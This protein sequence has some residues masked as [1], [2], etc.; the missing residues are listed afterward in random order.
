MRQIYL[1]IMATIFVFTAK[2]QSVAKFDDLSLTPESFWNG[3]DLSGSFKSG[4]VTFLNSFNIDWQNWSGFAYSNMSDVTTPG[5]GNQYSAITGKGYEESSNYA[6]C[7]PS[8]TADMGITLPGRITGFFV[9]NSTYAYLS[10]K[11]GDA[12]AKKFGGETGNDPDFFKLVIET[13]DAIGQPVDTLDFYL[14]DFRSVDNSK[15]YIL[16]NWTWVDLSAMKLTGNLRFSLSSGDN[17]FG[18]MNTPG[19]FC[20]DNLNYAVMV[21]SSEIQKKQATVF[22]NPFI[23][24]LNISG[25]D[26]KAKVI[27]SDLSGKTISEYNNVLNNKLINGLSGLKSGVYFIKIIDENNQFTT[28]LVKK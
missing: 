14:A 16:N 17:S 26:G 15:D 28:K 5:Y 24:Q 27:L 7:Y 4:D 1:A 20:I 3:S 19:Y 10:M 9:T 22:P 21:S 18:F 2:A 13:L 25:I 11:N 12:F 6:V 23:E 8:P